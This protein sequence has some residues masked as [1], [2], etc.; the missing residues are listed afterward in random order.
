MRQLLYS[1]F[2]VFLILSNNELPCSSGISPLISA[3]RNKY[4][5]PGSVGTPILACR[6]KIDNPDENGEG[7]ICVKGPNVM[8]GYFNNPE[9]TAEAFDKDGYFHT[10]DYGRLDEEGWIYITGRKKNLIILSNGKNIYP[11]ELES[12]L[13]KI[14][15]VSEV[16]V[17]AGESKVQKDKITIV[18]EIYPDFDLLKA[19]GVENPQSYFDDQVK[20]I[21]SKL[22]VYKTIKRV[23]LRDT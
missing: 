17:Y 11:E 12:E 9:A 3:N 6:V 22:P 10:G 13:Q 20:L 1:P 15:G 23:K 16:V 8:L 14:E 5:K 21:N 7:E 2:N 18:A 4:Q 19:R